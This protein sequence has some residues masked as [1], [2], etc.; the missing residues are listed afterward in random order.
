MNFKLIFFFIVPLCLMLLISFGLP[1]YKKNII[2]K[3]GNLI[4]PLVKKGKAQTVGA[5]IFAYCLLAVSVFFDFG[6]LNFV[7]PFCAIFG[8]FICAKE[9]VFR[10]VNGAYENL[11]ISGTEI[12]FYDEIV[13]LPLEELSIEE[14]EN[15]PENVIIIATKKRGKKQLILNNADE[16]LKVA[17]VVK[18]KL[19]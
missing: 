14:K 11:L 12:V 9:G 15:Y 7:I 13:N 2:K 3:A 19:V 6:K 18:E 16:V 8:L 4:V 1:F 17:A 10:S 5:Y